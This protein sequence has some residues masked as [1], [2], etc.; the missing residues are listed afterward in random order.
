MTDESNE[1]VPPGS[2]G[3]QGVPERRVHRTASTDDFERL[4]REGWN[5]VATHVQQ[6]RQE[7]G[8]R[9]PTNEERS[10]G[11]WSD[12]I[13]Y[14]VLSRLVFV[15]S[16]DAKTTERDDALDAELRELKNDKWRLE[17]AVEKAEAAAKQ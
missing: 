4:C 5:L 17:Q 8:R 11:A 9:P 6:E 13:E 12:V 2:E 16:K 7:T 1:S 15:I 14:Q 3:A 10:R